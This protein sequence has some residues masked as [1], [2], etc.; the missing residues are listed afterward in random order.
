MAGDSGEVAYPSWDSE[1]CRCGSCTAT[2]SQ[3]ALSC[4]RQRSMPKGLGGGAKRLGQ[5]AGGNA[6]AP[7]PSDLAA[8]AMLWAALPSLSSAS[9]RKALP[10][11]HIGARTANSA[12]HDPHRQCDFNRAAPTHVCAAI[13]KGN[14]VSRRSAPPTACSALLS[15]LR[16][17]RQNKCVVHFE[18]QSTANKCRGAKP[19]ACCPPPAW[20]WWP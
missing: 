2:E 12:A 3:Q 16:G 5:T 4:C 18:R 11:T 1:D 20:W 9:Y 8:F 14:A 19:G 10:R 13:I 6:G 7:V 15:P 17:A